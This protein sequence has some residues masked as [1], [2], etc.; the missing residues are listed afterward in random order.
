[1]ERAA[2]K[3]SDPKK[4]KGRRAVVSHISQKTSEMW[5]TRGPFW[6]EKKRSVAKQAAEKAAVALDRGPRRLKPDLFSISY[7][8]AKEGV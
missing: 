4:R 3:V 1:M 2:E 5:G 8:R 7:V 6:G